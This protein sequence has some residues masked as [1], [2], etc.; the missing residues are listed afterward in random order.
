MRRDLVIGIKEVIKKK[1]L[2]H[3][4]AARKADVGRTVITAIVNGKIAKISN[5]KL[6]DVATSLGLKLHLEVAA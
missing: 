2:T 5:D 3:V 4:Q 1:A 6:I